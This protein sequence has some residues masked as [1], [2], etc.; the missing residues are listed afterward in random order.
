[1]AKKGPM[2]GMQRGIGKANT[3]LQS[4]SSVLEQQ[5]ETLKQLTDNSAAVQDEQTGGGSSQL[6]ALK[7]LQAQIELQKDANASLKRLVDGQNKQIDALQKGN[8]DWKT[9]GDKFKDLKRNLQDALDPDTIKKSLLGP[10]TMFKGVRDKMED[11]DYV[12][13]MKALG[14]TKSKKEL[15]EDAVETRKAKTQ[16]LRSQSE[17]DR[18]KDMGASD[19]EIKKSR[20]DLYKDRNSALQRYN[21]LRVVQPQNGG[22]KTAQATG[23]D[24]SQAL[25]KTPSD[26]GA[27]AQST[28]DLLAE[29]QASKENQLESLRALNKQTDLLQQIANNTAGKVGSSSTGGSEDT[30]MAGAGVFGVIGAGFKVLG[31]GMR[32]IGGAAGKGIAA[33]MRGIAAGARALANPVVIVGLGA[34]TLAMMGIGKALQW[35]APAIDAFAPVLMKFAEVVGEVFLGA[36]RAIPDIIGTIGQVIIGVIGSIGDVITNTIDAV[37]TS[38]ERLAAID[39]ENLQSVALGIGEVGLALAAFAAGDVVA[40]IGGLV[41]GFLGAVT[42]QGSPIDQL[43]R[44]A[45]MGDKLFMAADAISAVAD[46]MKGFSEIDPESMKAV[47]EFPWGKATFFVAAGG[48]MTMA[49]GTKVY[50]TSKAN[51][52]QQ[53]IVDAQGKGGPSQNN[54]TQVNQSSVQN[55]TVKPSV[56][57]QESSQSKYMAS[58]Y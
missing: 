13:R 58:R 46:A 10:F 51:A 5:S 50:N 48:A 31:E 7:I 9:V 21:D 34:F 52:D 23:G 3:S 54:V 24:T 32:M 47:N 12:K 8:K 22:G 44:L 25:V 15:K 4:I 38:I 42:G 53:A 41:S 28:T 33:L 57:N 2:K 40:G 26:K 19:D 45:N 56:R 14:S 29:Q 11:V 39:G 17:I 1:M 36:I 20:P 43:E 49:N 16:V 35:A 37:T 18:L 30:G 55:T 27:L 6:I